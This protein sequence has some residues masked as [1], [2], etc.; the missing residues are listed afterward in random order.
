MKAVAT[1]AR[2]REAYE[3]AF[4]TARLL[5]YPEVDAF[6]KRMGYAIQRDRLE[7]AARVL[8]C[9]LKTS[10]PHW[11]HGRVIYAATRKYL[12]SASGPLTM[13]DIDDLGLLLFSAKTN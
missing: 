13:L 7:N 10:P 1:M 11:Q 6:E 12:E 8:A 9:P 5:E 2:T 4:Q 3:A